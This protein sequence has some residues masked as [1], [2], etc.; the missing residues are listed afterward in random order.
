MPKR[1]A[2]D[3]TKPG[4]T[5]L[6]HIRHQISGKNVAVAIFPTQSGVFFTM[7]CLAA[8]FTATVVLGFAVQLL[9][10]TQQLVVLGNAVGTAQ[11]AGLDLA[12]R[13]AHGQVGN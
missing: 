5:R 6:V 1:E 9:F 3:S 11:G 12:S 2:T 10:D 8:E 7:Y 13:G 4:R